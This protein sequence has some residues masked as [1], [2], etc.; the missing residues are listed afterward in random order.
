M[1][2]L[3]HLLDNNVII[4]LLARQKV[5]SHQTVKN[6]WILRVSKLW[7]LKRGKMAKPGCDFS[8]Q[9]DQD[10][11]QKDQ[12]QDQEDLQILDENEQQ[13]ILDGR[14]KLLDFSSSGIKCSIEMYQHWDIPVLSWVMSMQ[15]WAAFRSELV[16]YKSVAITNSPGTIRKDIKMLATT[17]QRILKIF[18][19]H[20]FHLLFHVR[21]KNESFL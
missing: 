18:L 5:P 14:V 10:Q 20:L 12:D 7:F 13:R 8:Q 9:K 4:S 3:H 11:V 2:L 17:K 1:L 16:K 15:W 6:L 21:M 19:F